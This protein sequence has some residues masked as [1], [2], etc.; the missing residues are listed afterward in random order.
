MQH[1]DQRGQH[2]ERQRNAQRLHAAREQVAAQPVRA[3]PMRGLELRR[4]GQVLPVER[5]VTPGREQRR[6]QRQHGERTQHHQGWPDATLIQCARADR[7][8]RT[9]G[10]R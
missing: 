5:V 8:S 4:H 1:A 2:A 9:S 7:A 6:G 3:Q 10:R